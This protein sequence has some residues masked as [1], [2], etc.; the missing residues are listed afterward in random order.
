M[1]R[2]NFLYGAGAICSPGGMDLLEPPALAH[3]SSHKKITIDQASAAIEKEPLVRPFGFRGGFLTELWQNIVQLQS[4]SGATSL[5]LGTESVLWSDANLFSSH[6]ETEGN[7]LMQEVTKYALRL[8]KG[9]TFTDPISLQENILQDVYAYGRQITGSKTLRMTFALNALV[10]LDNAAWMLYALENGFS[11]FDQLIPPVYRQALSA[12]HK[13][14]AYIPL[15]SYNVPAEELPGITSEDGAFFLKIKLG[16]PGTQR[17]MVEKDKAQLT[18]IHKAIGSATNSFTASGKLLYYF[19]A[20][21]RYETKDLISE[22]LDH[23]RKMG[24]FEQVALLEEPFPES[25]YT[26]VAGL[27]V[28]VSADESAHT[29]TDVLTRIQMGYTAIAL[30]PVAKTMSMSMKMAKTAHEHQ[31]PCFCADLTVNPILVE[32]NKNIAAR[33]SPFPGLKTG[34]LE[35]NGPQNYKHWD[36]LCSY[37]PANGAPS[38]TVK[39]GVF[40]LDEQFYKT[41]GGI[42]EK[43]THY[44]DL[45]KN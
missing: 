4:H 32:W 43:S 31:I 38:T 29:E 10:S 45:F 23:A 15:V 37:N 11:N 2:R 26:S 20:N 21:G 18:R 16:S 3:P 35:T 34:L 41:S 36:Q 44:M 19:D 9:N 27:G 14:L 28:R 42:L 30:K 22:F 25:Y 6:S 13:Q 40:E 24:A 7:S 12:R 5:G 39:K 8:V 1:N 33:L 17:E